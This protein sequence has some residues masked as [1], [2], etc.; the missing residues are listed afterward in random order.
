VN[1][2]IVR[3]E[4]IFPAA[5]VT[6][7]VQFEYVP[8]TSALNV[9][10]L[11]PDVAD[12]VTD[13]HEPPYEIV[14]ASVVENV[15]IGVVLLDGVGT[16][17]TMATVGAVV[18]MTNVGTER[19]EEVFPAASV[20]VIVQFEYVP[21]ASALNVTVL[22]PD[23]ADVVAEEQEP[24]YKIVPASVVENVYDGVVFL[25]GVGTAVTVAR[26]GAVVSI[27]N[28]GIVNTAERF[29][30]ASLTRTVHVEYV[31][32]ANVLNVIVLF[33]DVAVV[34]A[35][36]H[37]PPYTIVPASV[38]LNVYEGAVF[39]VGVGTEVTVASVGAVVSITK[40]GIERTE[41]IFPAASVTVI[42]Q[43]E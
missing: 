10:E 25:V 40:D 5:S 13:E 12:V 19:T 23:V 4:E 14:P 41:E 24:P 34:V 22:F 17:V 8:A 31:P 43:F 26:V 15:T 33:P 21:A 7:T 2:G 9:I 37:E 18:S 35:D 6:V 30:A 3:I 36:E 29:P 16:G 27:T 32:C 28:V 1:D 11:F 20:T 38:V 39:F 42:V